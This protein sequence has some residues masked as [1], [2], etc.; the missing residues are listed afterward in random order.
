MLFIV[1]VKWDSVNKVDKKKEQLKNPS[2][3]LT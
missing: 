2:H 1:G 3:S